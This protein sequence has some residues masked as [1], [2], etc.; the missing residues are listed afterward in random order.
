MVYCLGSR[1][2]N[3]SNPCRD[4]HELNQHRRACRHRRRDIA[5][6]RHHRHRCD[7]PHLSGNVFAEV[8]DEPDARRDAEREGATEGG[9]DYPPAL[10]EQRVG[11][12]DD[13]CGKRDQPPPRVRTLGDVADRGELAAQRPE[14]RADE[15][16]DESPT[17]DAQE[18]ARDDLTFG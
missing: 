11:E 18:G 9:E 13:S 4:S 15:R 14:R 16:G 7:R 10:D 6:P 1:H 3:N 17:Q 5:F 12:K 8:R 2:E